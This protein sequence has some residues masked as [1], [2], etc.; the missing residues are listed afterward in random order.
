MKPSP[1]PWI[2]GFWITFLFQATASVLYVDL[3]SANPTPPYTNWSIAATNIQDA[4]DASSDSDLILVTNGV[5][6]TGGRIVYGALTNRV[7]INKAVTVQS[8]NGPAVT[9]IQGYQMPGAMNGDSA[10]RCVYLTNNATL[11]GF[12]LTGGATRNLSSADITHEKSGGGVWCEST[13]ALVSNCVVAGNSCAYW[14]AGVYSGTMT[15]CQIL[16]NTNKT[17]GPS[18]GGGAAF[19]TL[20]NCTLSGN[21]LVSTPT[22]YGGGAST[23]ILSNCVLTGNLGGGAY[24]STLSYCTVSSNISQNSG[25]GAY[26]SILDNCILYNNRATNYGGGAADCTLNFCII[27]NNWANYGG[28][29]VYGINPDYGPGQNNT[30]V[31]NSTQGDAGATTLSTIGLS[32]AIQRQVVGED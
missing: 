25:G 16:N 4:V 30:V 7:V 19:G 1:Y 21:Q 13:N 20:L 2:T 3:N 27:S 28:G 6:Q 22:S 32:S 24:N 11:I 29:G 14:G 8:V 10:V 26:Q 17:G 18:G 5:Y 9:V 31:G 15:D 12:T 23:C